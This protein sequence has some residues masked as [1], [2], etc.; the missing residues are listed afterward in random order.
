MKS[1]Q[2]CD[3]PDINDVWYNKHPITNIRGMK[4]MLD[5][6]RVTMYS[7]DELELLVHMINNIVRLKQFSIWLYAM[8]PN[9]ENI[10]VLTMKEYQFMNTLEEKLKCLSLIQ[11]K[12]A[13]QAQNLYKVMGNPTVDDLN[14]NFWMNKIKY[15]VVTTDDLNLATKAYGLDVGETKVKTTRSRTTPVVSNVVEI[16]NELMEVQ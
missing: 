3:I 8:D 4:D 7:K 15:N 6:F 12:R 11:Q 13:K 2:K 9:D 16:T 1:H 5:N 14:A 10:F